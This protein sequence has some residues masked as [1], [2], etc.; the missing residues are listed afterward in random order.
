M[1][2]RAALEPHDETQQLVECKHKV[3]GGGHCLGEDLGHTE[4][5]K[6]HG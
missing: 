2:N 6:R 5:Q 4:A 3:R 1:Q